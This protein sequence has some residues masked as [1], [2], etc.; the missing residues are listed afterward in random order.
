MST[1]PFWM[2]KGCQE[3]S[4]ILKATPVSLAVDQFTLSLFTLGKTQNENTSGEQLYKS[5]Q[6]GI[7]NA[8]ERPVSHSKHNNET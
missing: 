6:L 2:S 7:Q 1:K 4:N 3:E 8:E 5:G